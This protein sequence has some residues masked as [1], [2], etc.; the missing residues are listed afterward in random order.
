MEE[1]ILHFISEY[2][3][4][5]SF[6]FR[7]TC[8]VKGV[9]ACLC[10]CAVHVCEYMWVCCACCLSVCVCEWVCACLCVCS[11]ECVS[12]FVYV[13]VSTES[14]KFIIISQNCLNVTRSKSEVP[15]VSCPHLYQNE[16]YIFKLLPSLQGALNSSPSLS[17]S[18]SC[19]NTG[20]HPTSSPSTSPW[21]RD[22]F[23]ARQFI[24]LRNQIT[25]P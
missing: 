14:F 17:E 4:I 18:V 8:K 25:E 1:S 6:F 22:R 2:Q 11:H 19:E 16:N 23:L 5:Y 20:R 12:T 13:C 10:M 24:F 7:E 21:I 9:C 15:H 3:R